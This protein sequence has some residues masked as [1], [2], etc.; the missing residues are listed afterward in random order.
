MH[1]APEPAGDVEDASSDPASLTHA[2][3]LAAV[4]ARVQRVA[5]LAERYRTPP[6]APAEL[7]SPAGQALADRY[8]RELAPAAEA[9]CTRS[10]RLLA[11]LPTA[12]S[13]EDPNGSV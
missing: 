10:Q 3:L 6:E 13:V 12:T 8:R 5:E 9:L 4:R 7:H 11:Q 2:E 1:R